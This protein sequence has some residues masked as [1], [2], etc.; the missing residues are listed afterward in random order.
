MNT[1]NRFALIVRPKRRYLEW[2]NQFD[3][4]K[5]TADELPSLT[6]VYLVD[7]TDS[8]ADREEL[9]D[10]YAEEIWEQQLDQWHT[11]ETAWPKNRTPHTLRDWFDVTFVEMVF[12]ADPDVEWQGPLD[13]AAMADAEI[14]TCQWCHHVSAP[15]DPIVTLAM[16]L[17]SDDPA[18]HHEGSVL[19]MMIAGE[20]RMAIRAQPGS[21][22]SAEG[23]HLMLAF[24]SEACATAMREAILRERGALLS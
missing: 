4:P 16:K 5:L 6:E 12:D 19:P 11:D 22:M 23:Q 1:V 14:R 18:L 24:C 17:P 9:I 7:A 2:A 13:D 21:Q 8:E 15:D 3:G 10:V 20:L